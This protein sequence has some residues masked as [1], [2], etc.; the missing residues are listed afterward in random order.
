MNKRIAMIGSARISAE[1]NVT[2]HDLLQML[3]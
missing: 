2:V 3:P 1:N